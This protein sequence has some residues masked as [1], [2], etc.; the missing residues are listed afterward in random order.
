MPAKTSEHVSRSRF[1]AALAIVSKTVCECCP[2]VVADASSHEFEAFS[3]RTLYASIDSSVDFFSR[4]IHSF[5]SASRFASHC[6]IIGISCD[7]KCTLACSTL[8]IIRVSMCFWNSVSDP[9]R[10]NSISDRAFSSA[11]R[12]ARSNRCK[13]SAVTRCT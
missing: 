8:S 12:D 6:S 1:S 2:K 9:S 11:S 5:F 10:L 13:D 4:S 7:C 3:S